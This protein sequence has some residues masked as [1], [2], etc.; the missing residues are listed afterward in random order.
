MLLITHPLRVI[1]DRE[2]ILKHERRLVNKTVEQTVALSFEWRN[3]LSYCLLCRRTPSTEQYFANVALVIKAP[4]LGKLSVTCDAE[5]NLS[6]DENRIA[7]V[8]ASF[9]K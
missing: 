1:G 3:P 5:N 7:I 9:V 8:A 6:S 2:G 4:H